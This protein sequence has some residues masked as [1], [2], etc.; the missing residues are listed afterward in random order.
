MIREHKSVHLQRQIELVCKILEEEK[1]WLACDIVQT[2]G[3]VLFQ[4]RL[5]DS[6]LVRRH[7][8]Q[9]R[10]QTDTPI[11]DTSVEGDDDVFI[12][13]ETI[14]APVPSMTV[15][16]SVSGTDQSSTDSTRH[17]LSRTRNPPTC[18]ADSYQLMFFFLWFC[19][20]V[21]FCFFFIRERGDVVTWVV[22]V[23]RF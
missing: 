14:P 3:P 9:I 2:L 18:Y 10:K 1:P 15:P 17:Y 20:F 19:F 22:S 12:S 7:Q 8:N 5:T 23:A 21:W 16:N 6:R 11:P 4:V 13:P